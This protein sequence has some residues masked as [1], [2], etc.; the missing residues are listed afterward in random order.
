MKPI[1]LEC[2]KTPTNDCGRHGPADP[3]YQPRLPWQ[4]P[5]CRRWYSPNCGVSALVFA[6]LAVVRLPEDQSG[7]ER[8][9]AMKPKKRKRKVPPVSGL[10]QA[11]G[12]GAAMK[13][14]KTKYNPKIAPGKQIVFRGCAWDAHWE[15]DCP[16][17]LYSPV[18]RYRIGSSA[19]IETMVEDVC[20]DLA[21][22]G[23]VERGFHES[24]LK[25]FAWRGWSPNGF[26]HRRNAIHF[27]VTV[28][29]TE[30]DDE[31][32]ELNFEIVKVVEVKP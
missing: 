5:G 27:A 19:D 8:G 2:A 14:F 28:R 11:Q 16:T 15:F 32:D 9:E 3:V 22:G 1:C 6:K 10:P 29:F 17:V 24:D 20:F 12:R 25:E 18:R 21:S 13:S 7:K 31:Y 23:A 4:C 30:P 26:R